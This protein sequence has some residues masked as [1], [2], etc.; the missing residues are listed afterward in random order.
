MTNLPFYIELASGRL[1]GARFLPSPHHDERPA[2]MPIDLLVI[3]NISLPPRVFDG[4]AVAEFFTGT[5]KTAAHPY[6]ADIAHLKVSAHLFIRR[7]GEVIQFVPFQLRAWH[8][9][10]SQFEGRERCNDFSIGI[11]LEGCDDVPY[12]QIQYDQLVAIT[13]LLMQ[14][15]P[16]IVPNRIVGHNMIAPGRKTDPGQ[17][18]DWKLYI[19][20][21]T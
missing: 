15:Y 13:R 4:E 7:S 18:F 8:A 19:G 21:L 17:T 14:A 3:H 16:G 10:Q 20:Q 6:Y 11:E 5:L 9:G 2:G 1:A 12:A